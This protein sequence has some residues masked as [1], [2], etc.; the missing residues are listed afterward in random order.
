M[1]VSAAQ[2]PRH[3][4]GEMVEIIGTI[5]T[6]ASQRKPLFSTSRLAEHTG[7]E[8][9]HR[10]NR[11]PDVHRPAHGTAGL[12]YS[13]G[14]IRDFDSSTLR[15]TARSLDPREEQEGGCWFVLSPSCR[16]SVRTQTPPANPGV[17]GTTPRSLSFQL[18]NSA[19]RV[20]QVELTEEDGSRRN[21]L[22]RSA[23]MDLSGSKQEPCCVC[24]CV[25]VTLQSAFRCRFLGS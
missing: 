17:L 15:Y 6:S 16:K 11:V 18:P 22:V 1:V 13:L 2:V 8:R 4:N 9:P 14:I 7:P 25:C 5:A 19:Q 12:L 23:N 10:P 24:L 21:I 3:P 20:R